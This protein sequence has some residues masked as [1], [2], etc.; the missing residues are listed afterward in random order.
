MENLKLPYSSDELK[1]LEVSLLN[2][3]SKLGLFAKLYG[4]LPTPTSFLQLQQ[5]LSNGIVLS[6]L[7]SVVFNVKI[8]GI[9]K[10]PKSE[11]TALGNLRKSMEVLR[12]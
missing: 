5:D 4:P 8:P 12:R 7:V 1:L 11:T 9:F 6:E 10:N 2:W 3:L